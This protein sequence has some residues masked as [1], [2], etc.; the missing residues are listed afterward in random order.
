M[1]RMVQV[2]KT[3]LEQASSSSISVQASRLVSMLEDIS[4]QWDVFTA[5][6]REY[7][8]SLTLQETE[9]DE[10]MRAL[11]E[12]ECVMLFEQM[13]EMRDTFRVALLKDYSSFARLAREQILSAKPGEEPD[14]SKSASLADA[15]GTSKPRAVIMEF[16][17][18]VGGQES[19]LFTSQV[20]RMY[21]KFAEN[22]GWEVE[23]LSLIPM[24]V[25]ASTGGGDGVKEAIIQISA[26]GGREDAEIY[27][28]LKWEAGVHRVQRIPTTQSLGKLQTSTMA[29]VVLPSDTDDGG[30]EQQK[31]DDVVD[32]K[33]VKT[34]VMRSRGAGGQHVNKTESA[35]RLTHLPSGI[36]VSM[37]DSRSQHQNRTKAWA[38]LRA[39]LLDAK[40]REEMAAN[41]AVRKDQVASMERSDRVRT[42]NFP[43]DR[44][45]D[46]RLGLS[47]SGIDSI[48]EGDFDGEWS[49][50][51]GR[52]MQGL[53]LQDEEN[54]IAELQSLWLEASTRVDVARK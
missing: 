43:Q 53:A 39:R 46:H 40:L 8:S 33:D 51:L 5:L 18:G 38:I 29:I 6:H 11:A 52:L 54:R 49:D 4:A 14:S 15:A 20:V 22:V 27:D 41:R 2:R 10:S 3:L 26:R 36:T 45:T 32:P 47:L 21:R 19:G 30:S 35:I 50:G 31:A 37:Q 16:R 42:F 34:E 23:E 12:E 25:N 28:R 44:V 1:R 13:E 9:K 7:A 17:P 48:I 24:E